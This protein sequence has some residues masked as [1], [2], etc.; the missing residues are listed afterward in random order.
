MK[1]WI[2]AAA[3]AF[4]LVSSFGAHAGDVVVMDSTADMLMPGDMVNDGK[5]VDIPSGAVVTLIMA[6]GE[7][8]IVN[9][10]YA[11]PIGEA[12][13][14]ADT[15][16]SLTASRGGETKVLGAVRAPKWNVED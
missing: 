1:N 5:V 3:S 10:P 7:T 12:Q 6:D 16:D 8:R 9:G 2:G 4:L 11:G 14:S 15:L 13:S